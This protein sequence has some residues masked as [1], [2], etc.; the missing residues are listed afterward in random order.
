MKINLR[1]FIGILLLFLS[2][3][4]LSSFFI[5]CSDPQT[6]EAAGSYKISSDDNF[7]PPSIDASFDNIYPKPFLETK[8]GKASMIATFVVV[9]GIYVYVT[10]QTAGSGGVVLSTAPTTVKFIG[11][12]IGLLLGYGSGATSA[13]LAAIG[14]G[15]MKG[16]IL[17]IG[18]LI[19]LGSGVITDVAIEQAI[20]AIK[21]EPYK[22]YE[23]LKLPLIEEG[24]S[25]VKELVKKIKTLEDEYINGKISISSYKYMI[26]KDYAPRLKNKFDNIP[27]PIRSKQNA[28]D[29]INRAIFYF[30]NGNYEL[31]ERDFNTA[32]LYTKESSFV[33]YGIALNNLVNNKYNDAFI[34]LQQGNIQE[35]KALQPYILYITALKD[36]GRYKDA[37]F[38]AKA[39]LEKIGKIF[40]LAWEAGEI[41]YYLKNYR[42]AAYYFEIAFNEVNE[43]IVEAEAARMVALSYKKMLDNENASKWYKKAL[44]K[45]K[46]NSDEKQKIEGMWESE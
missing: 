34:K 1:I 9:S 3:I 15:S 26:E 35:P 18:S 30:N 6:N 41:S 22:R 28:Y 39:G 14:L 20:D 40:S 8:T 11:T 21:K 16:G 27:T 31:S 29:L 5:A 36:N 42:D 13:G 17:V 7:T 10:M 45:A 38:L 43:N 37:L 19:S 24:S 12:Q 23:Y 25:D 2:V 4:F 33:L 32:L 44:K 46:E